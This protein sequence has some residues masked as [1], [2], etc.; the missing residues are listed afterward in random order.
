MPNVTVVIPARY[1]STRLPGK[2]LIDLHGKTM[3]ERVVQRAKSSNADEVIVATDDERIVHALEGVG[4]K[5]VMT[6]SSH[7]SGTDRVW[8][9]IAD[10]GLVD[11]D[12]VVNVQGDE[13]LIPPDV[14]NQAAKLAMRYPDCGVGTL[15]EPI[16]DFDEVFDPNIVKVVVDRF[17][18]ALYFSRAP[19]PWERGRFDNKESAGN[20][21]G[22]LR[23]LGIYA[24]KRSALAQ[25]VDLDPSNLE[26][27]ESLEQLRFLE[28]GIDIALERSCEAIP[29]GIDTPADVERV[30]EFLRHQDDA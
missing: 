18:R 25:F 11:E 16:K 26:Q 21:N 24:F 4:V 14:I 10:L 29:A 30:R 2:P 15:Y 1:G 8:E 28:N 5:V 22:W 17:G 7:Q 3:I 6:A 23:H 9:A 13:P 27:L 19:I 12:V 20:A